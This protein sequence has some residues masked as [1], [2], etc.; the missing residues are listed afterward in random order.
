[1]TTCTQCFGTKWLD[2]NG[3]PC[4]PWRFNGCY[5]SW[6]VAGAAPCSRCRG[7][8]EEP[9]EALYSHATERE[10]ELAI[11]KLEAIAR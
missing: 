9:R 7:T 6:A 3:S 11:D 10:A 8:G 5:P 2:A 1:M 4:D